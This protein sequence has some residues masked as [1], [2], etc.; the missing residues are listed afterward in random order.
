[1]RPVLFL[2]RKEL[3][4]VLRDPIMRIQI[5]VPPVL[6]LLV[7]S[8]AMT[9]EVARTDLALVDLDRSAASERLVERFTAS[10]RFAVTVVTGSGD[11]ADD[12]LLS[13]EA[14]AVLRLPAGFGRALARGEAT[15][16]Q[17]VLNAEDGAA[18]GV[19]RAYA[20]EIVGAFSDA[21]RAG[22]GGGGGGLAVRTRALY[23]PEG[24]YLG[25]MAIGLLASLVS[26][27]GI[28]LTAQ[29]VAR[30]REIG[31]LAQLHVTPLTR[32][33]FIA[34]KLIPFWGIGMAQLTLGLLII[35]FVLRVPFAG[36]VGWV[37]G[38][39][40]LY[41]VAALGLGLLI[42]TAV[43]TQQQA[44][45]VTF[46]VLVTLFFLGGIFTPVQS[47]PAWAQAVADVNPIQHFVS[48]LRTVLMKGG[49]A[50][51][52]ARSYAAMAAVSAVVLPLAILRSR[53]TAT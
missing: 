21:E 38:G 25:Y 43:Q 42:S 1:M 19:V 32:G 7:L 35:R 26:I 49:G 12:A 10:G 5:L 8:Q 53:K 24:R 15:D 9:F 50:A 16:V 17:L 28:L 34:G 18:A 13:R 47:M 46:F 29:N 36:S 23:N 40:A 37:Y 11:R 31:T 22:P 51:E 27:V 44:M 39:A 4:Q 30:E 45:F 48:V 20:G 6:Q 52:V 41:L 2:V 3:L 33:Q 14:G